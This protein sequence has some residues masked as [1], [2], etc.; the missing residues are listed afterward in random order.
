MQAHPSYDRLASHSNAAS[1][2]SLRLCKSQDDSKR[3]SYNP[4]GDFLQLKKC[5]DVNRV[6]KGKQ[7]IVIMQGIMR[8]K[9]L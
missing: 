1:V 3:Y 5:S 6:W 9:K 7:M 4:L 8:R 2:H